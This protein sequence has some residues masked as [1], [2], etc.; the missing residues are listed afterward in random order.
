MRI[1]WLIL[2]TLAVAVPAAYWIASGG[3]TDRPLAPWLTT[4][5]IAHRGQWAPGP[6]R[7]ENSLAA[8]EYAAAKGNPV[9]LDVQLSADGDL[10][11][12]HDDEVSALTDGEGLVAR[13][14]TAEL[15]QLRLAGGDERIPTLPQA[16]RAVG[17][18]VPILV[19]IKNRGEVGVL[20]DKAA[21]LLSA[22]EGEVAV[23]SFNPFSLKRFAESAPRIP[24][25]IFSSALRDEGLAFYE[26]FLLRHLLMNW[27]AKPDFVAYDIAELP[28][29]GTRL[30]RMRGRPL[31]GWT[32]ET[33]AQATE[34]LRICD[35]V[36]CD[37]GALP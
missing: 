23:A 12:F 28:S 37:P 1:R 36:I 13:M 3:M 22:Y 20:E 31:L 32:A 9:E 5:R 35:G 16:L 17:G 8:F 18:R 34:A 19:E 25:G 11:V 6:E 14:T 27:T 21:V 7:P 26:V 10:I 4:R 2:G 30:Q 29:P 24:R 15:T 33:E